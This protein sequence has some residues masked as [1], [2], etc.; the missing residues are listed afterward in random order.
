MRRSALQSGIVIC[1]ST[2]RTRSATARIEKATP[3]DR[4]DAA[5]ATF[6][7]PP[8]MRYALCGPMA[9]EREGVCGGPHYFSYLKNVLTHKP[10]HQITFRLQH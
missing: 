1:S 6:G 7:V 10:K 2:R 5:S 8:D 3:N 9:E 4:V